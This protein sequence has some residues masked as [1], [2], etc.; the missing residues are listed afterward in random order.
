MW[1]CTLTTGTGWSSSAKST[2]KRWAW[3]WIAFFPP[4]EGCI[5]AS[6]NL[7]QDE[8]LFRDKCSA[9][10]NNTWCMSSL[11]E[12]FYT[13][14]E[15]AAEL[16]VSTETLERRVKAGVITPYRD[17]NK[18]VFRAEDVEELARP[19]PIEAQCG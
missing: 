9:M 2:A 6:P 1:T 14:A 19:K 7:P 17:G 15:A 4:C 13:K 10:Q 18:I 8:V 12:Q 11:S 5:S 16:G 3:P